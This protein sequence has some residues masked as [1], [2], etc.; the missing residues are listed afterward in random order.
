MGDKEEP[1][2]GSYRYP[3]FWRSL[4]FATLVV[5]AGLSFRVLFL[6]GLGAR[7][8][9]I[10]FYPSVAAATLA[11]GLPAGVIAT[12]LSCLISCFMI[13]PPAETADW[14]A[15]AVFVG[16]C[17]I[18]VGLTEAL[19]RARWRA[20]TAT[21]KSQLAQAIQENELRLRLLLEH[22]P[23]ALAMFDRDM[24]YL[25][26]SRRWLADHGQEDR[27]L[28]GLSHYD[29]FPEIPERWREAHRR[30]LSGETAH[31]D[32]DYFPRADGSAS[33]QR[34]EA[35]PWRDGAGQIA[36]ILIFTEDV[37]ERRQ[38]AL[39]QQQ[40]LEEL[41]HSESQAREQ[42]A[43][44]RGV[45][46]GTPEA[47]LVADMQGRIVMTNRALKQTFGYDA[48]ELVGASVA[49][50]FA[51]AGDWER[52]RGILA[53]GGTGRILAD[54]Q[55]VDCLRKSG[56]VFPGE[57]A[58]AAYNKSTG[59]PAG[60]LCIIR[61]VAWERQ[62]EQQALQSQRLEAL[63]QL[64]GG[65]AHDFNN[66][67][68]V[69]SGNLQLLDLKLADERLRRHVAE[70]ER[71]IGMGVRLNQRLM[72]FA[73]RRLLASV[74]IDLNEYVAYMLELLHRTLGE[75]ITIETVLAERIWSVLVDPSEIENAILNLAINARDA[76]PGG[77]KLVIE[78][79]NVTIAEGGPLPREQLAPGDYVRLSIS[80]TGKG[81]PPQVLAR[82]FEPFFTTKGPG[83]GTGLGLASIYGFIKQSGGHVTL[84]SEEGRGTVVDIHLPKVE[85]G[86]APAPAPTVSNSQTAGGGETILVVE[87]N[88][89][90]RR[91]TA[92]R[93][94]ML[95]YE[96][97]EAEDARSALELLNMAER[98]DLVFSDVVMPGGMS[99]F[100]L[101][102]EI[103]A[104]WPSLKIL[105]TSG[106]PSD[107]DFADKNTVEGLM[108]LQKPYGP[109][110]LTKAIRIALEAPPPPVQA[111]ET[112]ATNT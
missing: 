79:A 9:Y 4:G 103:R 49:T 84:R 96:V 8:P 44:F 67:L 58:K 74:L 46:D 10:T 37:T 6:S 76:M 11:G 102:Q 101:A 20:E 51:N 32:E 5:A 14:L 99:G 13:A 72:T 63:G 105:L 15:L 57:I 108:I 23:N 41:R 107:I 80:D 12:I 66:L 69:I 42:Q 89:G 25:A 24:R 31:A 87:D 1:G 27:D 28:R 50:L 2:G 110:Q 64:T 36:G 18:I 73:R 60:C 16:N 55:N 111:R 93:L 62:R 40:L 91:V 22:T 95:G 26:V 19:L 90:V 33:W 112:S 85:S 78:T 3:S 47:I 38:A 29:V 45:F 39:R 52:L 68:T 98:V 81:M 56:E 54:I 109:A 61:D 100:E 82:A 53:A 35:L 70:A 34:W 92:E 104:R 21:R 71:A 97:L 59:E 17:A 106:F 75:H 30:A 77:G 43:L 83:K 7:L 94:E 86:A 65:I 88:A 48:S